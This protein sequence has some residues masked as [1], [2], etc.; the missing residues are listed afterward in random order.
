MNQR[1]LQAMQLEP[2]MRCTK[3]QLKEILANTPIILIRTRGS[4]LRARMGLGKI[5]YIQPIKG[6]IREIK[7]G[8]DAHREPFHTD[9]NHY[10]FTYQ[11]RTFDVQY[12]P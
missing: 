3:S 12:K 11:G 1:D 7:L 9:Q 6:Q 10:I 4:K 8:P 5:V 2:D